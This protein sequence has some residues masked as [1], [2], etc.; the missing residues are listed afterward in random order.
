MQSE[1]VL[2]LASTPYPAMRGVWDL[3]GGSAKPNVHKAGADPGIQMLGHNR[4][5]GSNYS[6]K[7]YTRIF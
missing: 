3:S 2:A 5:G 7:N 6:Q 4:E 1:P